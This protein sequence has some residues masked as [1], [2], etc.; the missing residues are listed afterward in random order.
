MR[1]FLHAPEMQ[2]A[3]AFRLLDSLKRNLCSTLSARPLQSSLSSSLTALPALLRRPPVDS[4]ILK[5][6]H[7]T[8]RPRAWKR[9]EYSW[10]DQPPRPLRC[11][12]FKAFRAVEPLTTKEGQLPC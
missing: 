2:A 11:A 3:H 9:V 5:E 12:L 7:G 6:R 4:G 1:N 8:G 10:A